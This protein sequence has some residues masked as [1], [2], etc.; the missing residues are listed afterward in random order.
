MTSFI[1]VSFNFSISD[2]YKWVLELLSDWGKGEWHGKGGI[3][4]DKPNSCGN[5]KSSKTD[6]Q[7]SLLM[8]F[9]I[10]KQRNPNNPKKQYQ[11]S[12]SSPQSA[13]GAIVNTF[14]RNDRKHNK[15][16]HHHQ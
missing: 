2:S 10:K 16:Q 12:Q 7:Q 9:P 13:S 1:K 11:D 3:L 5:S 14:S 6:F 15:K 8:S 4:A